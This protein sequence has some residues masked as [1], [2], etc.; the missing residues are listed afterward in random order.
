MLDHLLTPNPHDG[1][2]RG[3][4]HLLASKNNLEQH[5]QHFLL[6]CKVEGF[7]PKTIQNYKDVIRPFIAYC[8]NELVIEDTAMITAYHVR[9]YLLT[10]KDRVK[11]YTFHDYFRVI[12]R[13]FNWLVAEGVL[14]VSPMVNMKTPRVPTVL[15]QPFP[16]EDL[17]SLL[18]LCDKNTFLGIRNRAIILVFL[19]TAIRLKELANIQIK[20][21]DF[22]R[23]VIKVMGKG[24]RERVVAIQPR[25]QKAILHYRIN[26]N[27]NH[28]C[29]WVSEEREPLGLSGIYLMIHRLGKQ[30][31][32]KNVR[33]SPHTF[34]HTGATM[35]L[36]NGAG[37]FEV[38]AMLGH[39]T[40]TMTRR[41][42]AS[43][44]SEKAAEAHKRFS[45]VEHLKL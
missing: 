6:F 33:C 37:E 18:A 31:G 3:L 19:E 27:D 41:Y 30:A 42:V 36:N 5:F 15:V 29:L 9:S 25:T 39:S 24:A 34:R 11:P 26:R 16:V 4:D 32:L 43:I 20:D 44:N 1:A 38:Q 22:D 8:Y 7:A 40:L 28:P 12:K 13:Y 35:C 10:F 14:S 23:G 45:P 2:V 17:Q 21:I